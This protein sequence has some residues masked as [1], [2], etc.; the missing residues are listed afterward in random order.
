MKRALTLIASAA[1]LLGGCE[2]PASD[3]AERNDGPLTLPST[4]AVDLTHPFN[5]ETIYWPT[6]D[7][8]FQRRVTAQGMTEQGYYYEDGSFSSPEH[9]GTHVDAPRHFAEGAD[10]VDEIPVD[11]LVGRAVVIDVTEQA[12]ANPDYQVTTADVQSWESDHRPIPDG[13]IILIRTGFGQVWPD[14]ERYMGTGEK[15]AQGVAELQFPGLHPD[16]A[17]WLLENRNIKAV[18]ID[19]PSIDYG[20]SRNF[21]THRTLFERN[22]PAFENVANLQQL[23]VEGAVVIALPMKIEGGSGA[24]LRIIAF[25]P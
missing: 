4:E 20:Q 17:V 18:G 12:S 11:R 14:A 2:R 1:V 7:E 9:G 16:A 21:L 6:A 19:T 13:A 24:P 10:G 15:G 8:G 22:V 25:V 3:A 23:P 5:A